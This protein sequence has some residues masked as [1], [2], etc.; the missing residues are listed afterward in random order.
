MLTIRN[1]IGAYARSEHMEIVIHWLKDFDD[2]ETGRIK[3]EKF[4]YAV[5]D[6]GVWYKELGMGCYQKIMDTEIVLFRVHD[7]AIHFW[8]SGQSAKQIEEMMELE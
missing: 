2:K 4:I 8:L 3:Y 1:I 6:Y 7:D 5:R